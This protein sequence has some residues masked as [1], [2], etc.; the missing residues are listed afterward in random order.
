MS[1]IT[2]ELS[3]DQIK[4]FNFD[5]SY[6]NGQLRKLWTIDKDRNNFLVQTYKSGGPY[7]GT[8]EILRYVLSINN[9]LIKI[10]THPEKKV[11]DGK[12]QFIWHIYKIENASNVNKLDDIKKILEDAF[13]NFAFNSYLK[14]EEVHSSKII[15]SDFE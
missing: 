14:P 8:P 9:D 5:Y 2:E 13:N 6:M 7:E 4:H 10:Y 12:I 3:E 15:F 1:F 11:I